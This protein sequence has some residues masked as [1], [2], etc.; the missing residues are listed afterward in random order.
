MRA[1]AMN[2]P[3]LMKR[4]AQLEDHFAPANNQ[5]EIQ[6]MLVSAGGTRTEGD[7]IKIQPRSN[8]KRH[9]SRLRGRK[10]ELTQ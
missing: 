7:L 5:I 10:P 1:I 3:T 6:I 8:F 9:G 2:R 4:L